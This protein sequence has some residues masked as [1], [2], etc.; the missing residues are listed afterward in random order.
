MPIASI[1]AII[2]A[3]A[4]FA[5][6]IPEIVRAVETAVNLLTTGKAPTT[7]EQASIDAGLESAH[8]ALQA[9]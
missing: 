3:L 1:I 6:Q 4:A 8:A 7:E 2:E 9:S 5:P